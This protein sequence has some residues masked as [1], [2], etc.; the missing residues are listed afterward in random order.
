MFPPFGCCPGGS[1]DPE[2]SRR[3]YQERKLRMLTF[4]RDGVERQLAAVSAAISTLEQ[5]MNR[6]G[7]STPN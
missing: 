6:D 2:T 5:Q 1:N 4:W 3:S 7:A